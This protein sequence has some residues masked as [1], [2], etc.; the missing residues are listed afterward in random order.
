MC[1][2]GTVGGTSACTRDITR[3]TPNILIEIN[4]NKYNRTKDRHDIFGVIAESNIVVAASYE[5]LTASDDVLASLDANVRYIYVCKFTSEKLISLI[6]D[7]VL[8]SL[9]LP[10]SWME[11]GDSDQ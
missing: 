6:C 8:E 2:Y 5:V 9:S 3:K 4:I 10:S 7:N 1:K 11:I